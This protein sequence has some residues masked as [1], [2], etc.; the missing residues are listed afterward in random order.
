MI[1]DFINTFLHLDQHLPLW[2][3]QY[4]HLIYFIVFLV[5]FAETGLVIMPLLPGD[6]LLFA[7][8][9]MTSIEG[10]LSLWGL[11]I[12]LIIAGILGDTVNYHVGK[13]LGPKAFN[14]YPKIFRKE[15]LIATEDFYT[16]WGA[17]AI[18]AA[19]FAPIVRT[20]VPFVAGIGTMNYKKFLT[21]NI[22]GSVLWVSTFLL[23]G[24]F[25]GNLPI[26]KRNFHIVIFAVIFVSAIPAMLPI[27]KKLFSQKKV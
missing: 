25:F 19:R 4:G 7:L 6:S 1:T 14:K 26:V 18:V 15:Y 11:L 22:F 5:V 9:A 10:G 13:Y 16:K 20:F 12:S 2:V 24:H 23:A 17:F 27:I 8:G 21:Y 3:N